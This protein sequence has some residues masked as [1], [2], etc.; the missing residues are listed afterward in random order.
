MLEFA[1]IAGVALLLAGCF[2]LRRTM[3][4][5]FVY[6]GKKYRRM[7][8]GTF[9]DADKVRVTDG[10]LISRLQPEFEAAK[11]GRRDLSAWE[12]SD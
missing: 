8:D 1:V 11:Y 5:P 12:S 2:Y 6:E 9:Q 4:W 10:E 7:P 3:P